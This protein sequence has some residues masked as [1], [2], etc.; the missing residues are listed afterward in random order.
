MTTRTRRGEAANGHGSEVVAAVRSQ[1]LERLSGTPIRIECADGTTE[2]VYVGKL[3]IDQL[4]A[5]G[6]LGD[7]VRQVLT[8][9]QLAEAKSQITGAMGDAPTEG[10]T[11]AKS[12]VER[13]REEAAVEA[14]FNVLLGLLDAETVAALFGILIDRPAQ[15]CR[16][17][18]L[19]AVDLLN[20]ADA[21]LEHN[22]WMEVVAAFRRAARRLRASS[23]PSST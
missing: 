10:D 8:A 23:V 13:A 6:R 18:P 7:K 11:E 16:D 20:I 9:D 21:V 19:G 2:T 22:S 3:S 15:W 17:A 12:A 14:G 4:V 5:I 1:T